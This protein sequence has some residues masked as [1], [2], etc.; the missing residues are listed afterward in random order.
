MREDGESADEARADGHRHAP[1]RLGLPGR[2]V[3]EVTPSAGGQCVIVSPLR[4]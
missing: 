3:R 4:E 2:G 1:V